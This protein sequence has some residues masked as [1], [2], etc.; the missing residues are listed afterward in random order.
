MESRF[1]PLRRGRHEEIMTVLYNAAEE[2][3]RPVLA[4]RALKTCQ[5]YVNTGMMMFWKVLFVISAT[6]PTA[7]IAEEKMVE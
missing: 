1:H 5:K 4:L 7:L 6:Q 3:R 2:M